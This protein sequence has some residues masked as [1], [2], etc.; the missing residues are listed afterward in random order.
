MCTGATQRAASRKLRRMG[1]VTILKGLYEFD[2]QEE[3]ART[4]TAMLESVPGAVGVNNHQ[5]SR[6]TADAQL[7]AETMTALRDRGLFFIDSRTTTETVAY[8]EAERLGVP[9]AYRKV[10]LD[11]V[12]DRGAIR[13]ELE[14][15]ARLAQRQG[16]SIAIGHPHPTTMESLKESLPGL[17]ARGIRLVFA[18]QLAR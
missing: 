15:A 6:A 2:N 9:A 13:G 11:D 10:F 18:S 16:W 3:V 4:L 14:R 7:M 12:P 5:G 8:Q 17:E 1:S